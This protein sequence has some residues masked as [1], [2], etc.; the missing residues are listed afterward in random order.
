MQT[1]LLVISLVAAIFA[2]CSQHEEPAASAPEPQQKP[3]AQVFVGLASFYGADLAGNTTASGGSYDPNQMTAAH[4]TLPF[5]T[6]VLVTNLENNKTVMVTITDRGPS[7]PDR[8]LDVSFAAARELNML[9]S[10]VVKV[11][12]EV[13]NE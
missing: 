5:G 4:R 9:S 1:W 12:V 11:R 8:L 3:D 6:R 7:R 13:V 10:G 2:G